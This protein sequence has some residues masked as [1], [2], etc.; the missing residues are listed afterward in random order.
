MA[1]QLGNLSLEDVLQRDN[2]KNY[3]Y[4]GRLSGLDRFSWCME[5]ETKTVFGCFC[6][7]RVSYKLAGLVG[8]TVV[9]SEV[10]NRG[11]TGVYIDYRGYD[12]VAVKGKKRFMGRRYDS[13][14]CMM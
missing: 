1:L 9:T 8:D 5:K 11:T 13:V 4:L 2:E 7:E 6:G 14:T 10:R 3:H 12:K